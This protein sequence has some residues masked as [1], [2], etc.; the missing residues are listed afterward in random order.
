MQT[1]KQTP[2]HCPICD[3]ELD[4]IRIRHIGDVTAHLLWQIHAGH[5]PEHGWF[6]AELISKPPR[7]IFPVDRPWGTARRVTIEGRDV[8]AFPTVWNSMDPRQSVDAFDSQYWQ[9]DWPRLR[10]R[11]PMAGTTES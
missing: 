2:L 6:Q 8:F 1:G 4:D 9:V 10:L 3:G 5:C 11:S 7:E